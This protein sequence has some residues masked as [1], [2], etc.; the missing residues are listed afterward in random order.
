MPETKAYGNCVFFWGRRPRKY[1]LVYS[2]QSYLLLSLRIA[3]VTHPANCQNRG[4]NNGTD[5]PIKAKR[6]KVKAVQEDKQSHNGEER[7][8]AA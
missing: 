2:R 1:H 3:I 8:S 4:D 6:A 7:D 5:E